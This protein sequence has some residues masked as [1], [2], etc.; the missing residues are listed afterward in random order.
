MTDNPIWR[1]AGSEAPDAGPRRAAA[2]GRSGRRRALI[3]LAICVAVLAV[4]A[5]GIVGY[6]ARTATQS[7]SN[8][9]REPD[10]LPV[11]VDRPPVATPT[12][13]GALPAMNIVLIGADDWIPKENGRS[14]S[15]MVVHISSDRSKVYIVSFPRDMWVTVPGHGQAKINAAYSWGGTAL[16]VQ[17][18]EGLT[19]A[20]IDHVVTTNLDDFV[21]LVNV[22]GG[23]TVDN[24]VAST[25]KDE[26]T[27]ATYTYP[28]GQV[29]LDGKMALLFSRQRYE[30]PN[31]D[32][33][34]ALRQRALIKALALKV[35]TPQ[36]LANPVMLGNVMKS[37]AQYVKVDAGMTDSVIIDLATSM[38]IKGGDQI[39]SLQAPITGFG[40]SADGQ[41]IDLVDTAG[42]AALGHALQTDTMAEYVA[43][44]PK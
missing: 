37:V 25:A 38:R 24:P 9:P 8:I 7:L 14:D 3:V 5:V 32:L 6:L 30:L 44:H 41:S 42:V 20:H 33:D 18:L 4:A 1:P 12:A 27:G 23:V 28:K 34:R 10:A 39:I 13:P 43:A 36:V 2:T 31:G 15:L 35:A 19:G 26:T 29:Y 11:N 22:V 16:S 40:T 21:N 17:T